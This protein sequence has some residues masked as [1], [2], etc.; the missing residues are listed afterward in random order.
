MNQLEIALES[1]VTLLLEH[2]DR[3]RAHIEAHE[4]DLAK[5]EAEALAL[6][7]SRTNRMANKLADAG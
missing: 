3:M 1:R 6:Y 5:H 2:T 4:F 7:C